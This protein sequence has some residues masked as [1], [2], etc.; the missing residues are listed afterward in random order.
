MQ[1][2]TSAE[3]AGK[4]L[5]F[6]ILFSAGAGASVCAAVLCLLAKLIV[7]TQPSAWWAIPIS[8]IAVM[9]GCFVSGYILARR[10]GQNGLFCGLCCGLFFF[11]IFLLAAMLSGSHEYTAFAAIKY[12]CY[13]LA[14]ALGGYIG[15][16]SSERSKRKAHTSRQ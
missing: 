7:A 12:V 11:L 15:L 4:Q 6:S 2:R 1:K 3:Y 5:L 14:G 16:L 9:A 13:S 8:A 10:M